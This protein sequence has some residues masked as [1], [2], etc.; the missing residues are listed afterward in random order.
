MTMT[1]SADKGRSAEA[2]VSAGACG[3]PSGRRL[4]ADPIPAHPRPA[5]A[6]RVVR[7]VD[8]GP[9]LAEL[10]G[11]VLAGVAKNRDALPR[12]AMSLPPLLPFAEPLLAGRVLRARG[13]TRSTEAG[14]RLPHARTTRHPTQERPQRPAA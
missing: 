5:L 11:V 2:A 1:P 6:C 7:L 10:A 13:N 3:G 14:L 9:V 4:G 12:L 8:A